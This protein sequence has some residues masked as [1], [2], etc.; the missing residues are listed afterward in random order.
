MRHDENFD[1]IIRKI[2]PD[3]DAAQEREE[4][5]L[6]ELS[7]QVLQQKREEMSRVRLAMRRQ[8]RLKAQ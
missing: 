7:A 5:R 4:E 1:S 6:A 8:A 3:L 2:Y